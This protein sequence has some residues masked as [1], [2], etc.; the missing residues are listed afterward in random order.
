[1]SHKFRTQRPKA[2][3]LTTSLCMACS[4]LSVSGNDRG[5][6]RAGDER[7]Q[8][9][10]GFGREKERAW[11]LLFFY[12][13]PLVAHPLF[14]HP[15]WLKGWNR[16]GFVK[17]QIDASFSCVCPFIDNDCQS[18]LRMNLGQSNIVIKFDN[19]DQNKPLTNH[20]TS[21]RSRDI[22]W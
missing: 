17:H 4:R 6:T 20:Y 1:M 18:S 3:N 21:F 22:I 19:L 5:K 13:T 9:R 15:H 16:L 8:R 12:Q 14:D 10:A 2:D 11:P 7:D